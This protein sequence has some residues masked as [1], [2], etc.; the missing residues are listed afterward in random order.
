VQAA[1]SGAPQG[2]ARARASAGISNMA[3][4]PKFQVLLTTYE[5]LLADANELAEVPWYATTC[6]SSLF[7]A[8]YLIFGLLGWG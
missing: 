8:L 3:R 1:L 2:L 4:V 7:C 5:V 6:P